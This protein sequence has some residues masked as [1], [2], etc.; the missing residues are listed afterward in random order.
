MKLC[1]KCVMPDTNPRLTFDENGVC[2]ACRNNEYKEKIDWNERWEQ[3]KQILNKYRQK[4]GSRF[5]C[6]IPVSGGK[7]STYQTHIIKKEFGMTPLC[8][9]F[10][11]TWMTEV[12]RNNL[13]NLIEKLQVAHI[14]YTP[15]PE[16]VKNISV[17]SLR[18][19]GDICWHCHAGVF[20]F[21]V[22]VAVQYKIP[23]LIWGEEGHFEYGG[24]WSPGE[25]I[26]CDREYMDKYILKG[27]RVGD[28]L[29]K[30]V[31]EADLAPF[32]YPSDKELKSLGLK[33]IF[34]GNY[35]RWD[36][37]KQVDF[38]KK[39][40]GWQ[41][42]EFD[43]TYKGYDNAECKF[44]NGTHM[45]L[46]YL[47]YGVDRVYDHASIDIRNGRMTRE[48]GLRMVEK[49]GGKRPKDLDEYLKMVGMSEKEFM[50]IAQTHVEK[51]K[52]EISG[53]KSDNGR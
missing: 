52:K 19:L 8:V 14:M 41:E 25:K 10:N 51:A 6:I 4:D 27:V 33:G 23:L 40:Y 44:C 18:K 30:G 1:K 21:P 5:D 20:S 16:V 3:L 50:E 31:T 46:R 26:V 12:G 38:I 37:Q 53:K 24:P 11:H 32:I 42:A 49:Y 36:A 15:N 22:Q 13:Q 2:D 48:E 35:I 7:D 47:K 17:Q 29:C 39:E 28:M 43:T 9:T 45:Y 34:L